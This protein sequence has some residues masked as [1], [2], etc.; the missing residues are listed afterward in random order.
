MKFDRSRRIPPALRAILALLWGGVCAGILAAPAL[1]ARGHSLAAALLYSLFSPICHQSS[2]RCFSLLGRQWAVCQRCSGIYFGLLVASFL[3]HELSIIR[4]PRG[5]RIWVACA[6]APML[7]D[8]FMQ[9]T[10]FWAGTAACRFASGLLFG[11][12]LSSLLAPALVES[13]QRAPWR[14]GHRDIGALGGLS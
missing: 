1:A 6:T 14:R 3:P 11:L 7:L 5:R 4:E 12:M 9:F 8:V 13:L 10:G 2:A